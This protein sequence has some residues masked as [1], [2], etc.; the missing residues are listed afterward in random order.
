MNEKRRG[1]GFGKFLLGIGIGAGMES[2]L[3]QKVE[4]KLEQN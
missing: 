4:K 3:H 2:Y 1:N